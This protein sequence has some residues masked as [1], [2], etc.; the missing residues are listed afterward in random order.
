MR[1]PAAA[2]VALGLLAPLAA[3]ASIEFS[4][5]TWQV[6]SGTGGPGPNTFAAANVAL[7]GNGYLHLKIAHSGNAWT[8]A[9]VFSDAAFGFGTYRFTIIG[10]PDLMDANVVLGLFNYTTPEIGPD[11]TNEID[12]EFATWGGVQAE[13]GNWTVWPALSGPAPTTH[14]FDA[15]LSAEQ[16][17]HDFSWSAHQVV[18]RSF[19]G[20]GD[21]PGGPYASWTFA[22]DD[23][24]T[25][26]P[27]HPLPVHMNLWLFQGAAPTDAQEVDITIADFS[28]TP[29]CVFDDGFEAQAASCAPP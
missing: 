8:T 6:R 11:G 22:P 1:G 4:G 18:Y 10:R 28:F 12:I 26:I 16:S 19:N 14:A 29:D 7:D 2:L 17:T 21:A 23:F 5:Y 9:E 13:H 3:S 27:Q 24:A 15:T 25:R 20:L